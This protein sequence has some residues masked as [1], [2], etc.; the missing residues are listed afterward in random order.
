MKPATTTETAPINDRAVDMYAE[1]LA[2]FVND[3]GLVDY[4]SLRDD[5]S[6]LKPF[7]QFIAAVSPRSHPDQFPS[8]NHAKAYWINAYNALTMW[9]VIRD[10]VQTSVRGIDLGL[11]FFVITKQAVGGEQL[12]LYTI[13]NSILRKEFRDPR[14]HFAIN[15]ASASCPLLSSRL[16]DGEHLEIQLE[17]AAVRFINDTNNV[18]IDPLKKIV[19]VSRI[20]K[21]YARDFGGSAEEVIQFIATYHPA[22]KADLEQ[23]DGT[24]WKLRYRKYNWSL[25]EQS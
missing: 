22:L 10:G 8:E 15:C 19:L 3:E 25:N 23:Q 17:T 13:E 16:F 1:L 14:I 6:L 20:F 11:K 4:G 21:W 9:R 24:H 5:S 12:T 7:V 2:Q 18:S